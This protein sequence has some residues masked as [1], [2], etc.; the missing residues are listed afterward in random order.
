MDVN[1][2]DF[3]RE[4]I[5]R[6]SQV[7]VVVD[8]WAPWCG[9]CRVLGPALEA[10]VNE[11][12]G[13]A[14]L[15]KINIDDNPGFAQEY[16]VR[17]IPALKAF[18]DGRVVAEMEGARDRAFLRRWLESFLPSESDEI[19]TRANALIDEGRLDEVPPLL[20][21]V[22]PRSAAAER[23]PLVERRLEFARDAAGNGGSELDAKWR[24]ASAL[25]AKGSWPEALEAFLDL[26]TRSRAYRD[27]GAR[28]A[29]L[30][31]FEILGR[32]NDVARDFRR[33][34]Q[35]I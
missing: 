20:G 11:L 27:D 25:A 2:A 32:G 8:F 33:R 14:A 9:P 21:R 19:V 22:D 13:R 34:L 30:S 35:I 10:A 28:L 6:S 12:G 18:R 3:D 31:I 29:M 7:P 4:V 5:A 17:A 26:V 16:G 23:V 1:Q 15:V 24:Q